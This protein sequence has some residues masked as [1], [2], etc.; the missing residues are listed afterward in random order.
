MISAPIRRYFGHDS[1]DWF[2][3]SYLLD[4][5]GLTS[6]VLKAC[7]ANIQ[8]RFFVGLLWFLSYMISLWPVFERTFSL[9]DDLISHPHKPSQLAFSHYEG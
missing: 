7:D 3:R 8:S 2:H 9:E 4:W 6:V 1:L 5:Y